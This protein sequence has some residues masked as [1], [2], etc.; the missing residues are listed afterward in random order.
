MNTKENLRKILAIAFSLYMGNALLI[1]IKAIFPAQINAVLP[2][3]GNYRSFVTEI[4]S[5]LISLG[6]IFL[7]R[8]T[9]VLR[10]KG[11]LFGKGLICGLPLIIIY[12]LLLIFGLTNLPGK[13]LIPAAEII[14][15]IIRW[16]LIGIAEEGLFRGV[17]QELFMDIFGSNSRKGVILSIVSAATVFGLSHFQN[18]LAGAQLP[19]VLIQVASAIASGLM[20]GAIAYRSGRSILPAMLIHSLIDA[21]SFTYSGML[22]GASDV[23]SVNS[24]DLRSII[25]I[26]V[27]VGI[28]IFL[29]RKSKTD[30]LLNT[31]QMDL[32]DDQE[33]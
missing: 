17:I 30:A 27:F 12:S 22:W 8:K 32:Q 13:T 14:I 11:K 25:M 33:G 4:I 16:F 9:S 18:L 26:P 5:A 29:M 28:F 7:F 19:F 3:N 24:L 10:L 23:D 31:D 15:V 21:A 1:T 6:L 20:F 2:S